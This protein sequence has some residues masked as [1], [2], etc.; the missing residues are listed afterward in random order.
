M[1]LDTIHVKAK[2]YSECGLCSAGDRPAMQQHLLDQNFTRIL[3]AEGYHG[4]AVAYQ[5]HIH[6]GMVSDEGTREVVR[7]HDGDGL[8]LFVLGAERRDG[9][10]LAGFGGRRAHGRVGAISDLAIAVWCCIM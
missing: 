2:T 5:D 4:Q 9:D 7:R 6:T 8:S 3:H 10:L 1:K